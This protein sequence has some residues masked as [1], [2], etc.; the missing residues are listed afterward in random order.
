[1]DAIVPNIY[2]M[3]GYMLY[4]VYI[5]ILRHLSANVNGKYSY[6]EDSLQIFES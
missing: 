3:L 5:W 6:Q 4:V 1:M 2:A